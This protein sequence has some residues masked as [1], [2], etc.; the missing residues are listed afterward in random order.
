METP[1]TILE[2]CVYILDAKNRNKPLPEWVKAAINAADEHDLGQS[3]DDGQA[4]II[5]KDAPDGG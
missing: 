2:A 3:Y 1:R 4:E 5:T